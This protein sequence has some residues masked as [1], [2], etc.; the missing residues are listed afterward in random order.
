MTDKEQELWENRQYMIGQ[1]KEL[2]VNHDVYYSQ[3]VE[4]MRTL[5]DIYGSATYPYANEPPEEW[6]QIFIAFTEGT[7][8][9][10]TLVKRLKELDVQW[11][12]TVVYEDKQTLMPI[13]LK[14]NMD[15]IDFLLDKIAKE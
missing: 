2:L 5:R 1:F 9:R 11:R 12:R 8:D 10:P 7:R 3:W 6:L 14:S 15:S 13:E 4:T